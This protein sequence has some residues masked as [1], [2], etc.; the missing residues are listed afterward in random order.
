MGAVARAAAFRYH[1]KARDANRRTT[2]AQHGSAGRRAA[3][4]RG[5][6]AAD[7]GVQVVAPRAHDHKLG[8]SLV[9]SLIQLDHEGAVVH[10]AHR[11]EWA[12]DWRAA[13]AGRAN[14]F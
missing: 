7:S 4:K 9:R 10:C 14:A 11:H 12:W 8:A 2:H 13:V 1:C 5:V 6:P 3:Q